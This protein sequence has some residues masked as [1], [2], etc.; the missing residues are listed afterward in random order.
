MPWFPRRY[1][2]RIARY[3]H[4]NPLPRFPVPCQRLAVRIQSVYWQLV[5]VRR[6]GGD[7]E[8]R[9]ELEAELRHLYERAEHHR[10][11]FR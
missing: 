1:R 7:A 8:W 5:D 9:R 2:P 6:T 3:P 11:G 10:C 4:G